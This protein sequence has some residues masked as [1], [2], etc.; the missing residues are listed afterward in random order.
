MA[1]EEEAK[2][3]LLKQSAYVIEHVDFDYIKHKLV[4]EGILSLRAKADIDLCC[5]SGYEKTDKYFYD[6]L[7]RTKLHL[8][9]PVFVDILAESDYEHVARRLEPARKVLLCVLRRSNDPEM[10]DFMR[11]LLSDPDENV[12]K[13][14]STLEL[15]TDCNGKETKSEALAQRTL[16]RCWSLLCERVDYYTL[17]PYIRKILSSAQIDHIESQ[18]SKMRRMDAFL[19][20]LCRS[21]LTHTFSYFLSVFKQPKLVLKYPE[22]SDLREQLLSVF[23]RLSRC[24]LEVDENRATILA[25][26]C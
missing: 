11:R 13:G 20:V 17:C 22:F 2:I 16:I 8:V 21:D 6:Y 5:R 19:S 18:T 15:T 4:S 9:L 7:L 12:K 26:S 1:P 10:E 3:Q 25:N 24:C 23:D 14:P